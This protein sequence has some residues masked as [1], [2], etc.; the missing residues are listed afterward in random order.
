[1]A[2]TVN[3]QE[4]GRGSSC[5]ERTGFFDQA[6]GQTDQDRLRSTKREPREE[7]EYIGAETEDAPVRRFGTTADAQLA[8]QTEEAYVSKS[9]N[10]LIRV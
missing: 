5:G 8:C 2:K 4:R 7:R 1:M 10:R 3:R 6:T 9:S